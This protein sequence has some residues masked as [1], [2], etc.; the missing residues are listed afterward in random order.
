MMDVDV[1]TI[2]D[3]INE[4]REDTGITYQQIADASGVPRTTVSR[5]LHGETPNPTSKNL[6]DIARAVGCR[7]V[8]PPEPDA[9]MDEAEYLR[10]VTQIYD[11]R[12][13]EL[14]CMYNALLAQKQRW[15]VGSIT[16]IVILVALVISLAITV[17]ILLLK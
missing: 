1:G 12:N 7:I 16:A 13:Q 15:L 14:R 6:H 11:R 8:P 5:I 10:L 3:R 9:Q 2:I 17:V 4:V